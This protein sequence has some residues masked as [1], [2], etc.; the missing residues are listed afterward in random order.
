M[1]LALLELVRLQPILL[2]Q[3]HNFIDIFVKK[4]ADFEQVITERMNQMRDDWS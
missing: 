3:E 2:R 4:H 1:F